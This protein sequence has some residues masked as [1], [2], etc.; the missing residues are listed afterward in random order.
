M[1]PRSQGRCSTSVTRCQSP[2]PAGRTQSPPPPGR[3][4]WFAADHPRRAEQGGVGRPVDR[5][6]GQDGPAPARSG[7]LT[8]E[9]LGFGEVGR[10]GR[11]VSVP[12]GGHAGAPP[13]PRWPWTS[14]PRN[15]AS[16]SCSCATVGASAP[17]AASLAAYPA[18]SQAA[19]RRRPGS[20]PAA[21]PGS[22]PG[23]GAGGGQAASQAASLAAV[24]GSGPG[25][26]PGSVP[27]AAQAASLAAALAAAQAASTSLRTAS[28]AGRI[29]AAVVGLRISGRF[30]RVAAWSSRPASR[31]HAGVLTRTD[32]STASHERR[33]SSRG[34]PALSRGRR[35]RGRSRG[36][37]PAGC[38]HR[39]AG[40][41]STSGGTQR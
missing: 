38:G 26:V 35:R 20:G 37:G 17:L 18:A 24:P 31:S 16:D 6:F 1:T 8:G 4:R 41:R 28:G 14:G 3:R 27:A 39:R 34:W 40:R 36:S 12:G 33:F 13:S 32:Q 9:V 2:S 10:L 15:R 21:D 5:R 7:V 19:A 23:G 11:S 30:S 25:S 22:G 29:A